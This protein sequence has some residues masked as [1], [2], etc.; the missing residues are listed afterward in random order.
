MNSLPSDRIAQ[1]IWQNE[2]QNQTNDLGNELVSHI[3]HTRPQQQC[4]EKLQTFATQSAAEQLVQL[5]QRTQIALIT[6]NLFEYIS[7]WAESKRVHCEKKVFLKG[8]NH[9]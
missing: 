6:T 4:E 3:A 8:E 5:R 2:T 1:G 7:T 9:D